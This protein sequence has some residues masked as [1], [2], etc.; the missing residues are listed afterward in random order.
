MTRQTEYLSMPVWEIL[1]CAEAIRDQMTM[2]E[3]MYDDPELLKTLRSAAYTIHNIIQDEI[4]YGRITLSEYEKQ[5]KLA[6]YYINSARE[7]AEDID[8]EAS[9][10][11]STV[12]TK[13]V[14]TR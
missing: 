9:E 11:F 14:E 10:I 7:R 2:V 8:M 13:H 4:R 12:N 5:R 1:A 6:K 3:L